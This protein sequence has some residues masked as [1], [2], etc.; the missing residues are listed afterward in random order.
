[1]EYLNIQK[2]KF[3]EDAKSP[4]RIQKFWKTPEGWIKPANQT[5]WWRIKFNIQVG[6]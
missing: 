3:V 2:A 4:V 1:M 5:V 6:G